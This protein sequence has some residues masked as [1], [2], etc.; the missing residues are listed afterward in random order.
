MYNSVILGLTFIRGYDRVWIEP[1]MCKVYKY[2]P[3]LLQL[4]DDLAACL[5]GSE[6][7]SLSDGG[8]AAFYGED[9]P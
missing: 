4:G 8:V 5:D 9:R 3:T 2:E 1:S 6:A 7:T